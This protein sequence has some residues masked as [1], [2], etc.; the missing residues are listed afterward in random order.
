MQEMSV[1]VQVKD[2]NCS[3]WGTYVGKKGQNDI[4]VVADVIPFST[5]M[6]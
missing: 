2:K 3:S 6:G 4:Q 5:W 1:F